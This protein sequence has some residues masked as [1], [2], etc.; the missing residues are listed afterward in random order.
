[1]QMNFGQKKAI[2]EYRKE[3]HHEYKT[4]DDLKALIARREKEE[5]KKD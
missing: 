2:K 4:L 5:Q 1:M 3:K